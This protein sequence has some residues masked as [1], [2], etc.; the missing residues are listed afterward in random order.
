MVKKLIQLG[1]SAALVMDKPI[2]ES[3]NKDLVLS[4]QIEND[5]EKAVMRS[6]KEIN[7]KYGSVLK[8][9]GE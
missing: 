3:L 7:K 4:P 6:L 8:R 1:D 9:L 2:M 5:R